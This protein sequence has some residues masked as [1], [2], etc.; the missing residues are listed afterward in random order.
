MS[1]P[2]DKQAASPAAPHKKPPPH[3]IAVLIF[4]FVTIYFTLIC[5][6]F[7]A[8][9]NNP[10]RNQGRFNVLVADFDGGFL[11]KSVVS[12]YQS[13]LQTLMPSVSTKLGEQVPHYQHSQ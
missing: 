12:F 3:V 4:L 6:P 11:G 2:D 5:V 13:K 10:D 8:A 1:S 9:A 7:L